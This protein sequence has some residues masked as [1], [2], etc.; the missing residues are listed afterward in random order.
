MKAFCSVAC[1][2]LLAVQSMSKPV[3]DREPRS[4]DAYDCV[5]YARIARNYMEKE[6]DAGND[7]QKEEK[8]HGIYDRIN[9]VLFVCTNVDDVEPEEYCYEVTQKLA[10]FA[11]RLVEDLEAKEYER[12]K[13]HRKLY[14]TW[15]KDAFQ[16]DKF[17]RR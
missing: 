14:Y 15:M 8:T 9:S 12:F 17:G 5:N 3:F 13:N 1:L 10:E 11:E 4:T 16:C 2:A 7:F 6:Q